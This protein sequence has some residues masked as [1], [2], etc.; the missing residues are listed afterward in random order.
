[1]EVKKQ[2]PCLQGWLTMPPEEPHIIGSRC[3][4]CGHYFFPRASACQN[5][6]C[7]KTEPLEEVRL[8]RRGKL[9]SYTINHY[10]PPPPFHMPDP[11]VPFGVAC[12]E[13]PEGIKIS[14]QVPRETDLSK[15]KIGMEMETVREVLYVDKEGT[16]VMC[17]M[18]KP[19]A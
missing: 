18:F 13:F 2:I 14:G 8:S 19:V 4:S 5:P 17:W 10:A 12:V 7:K 3:K 16:E 9:Y 6:L 1:M 11:F 15:I